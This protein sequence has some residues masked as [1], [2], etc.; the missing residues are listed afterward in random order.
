MDAIFGQLHDKIEDVT[1]YTEHNQ[2]SVKSISEAILVYKDG[3]EK[4]VDDSRHVHAVS[5]NMIKCSE[6]E[7]A[8]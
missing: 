2:R 1:Q 4:I 7:L 8:E 3:V 5:E 6:N